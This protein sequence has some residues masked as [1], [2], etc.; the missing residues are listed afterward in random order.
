MNADI[1]YEISYG[2]AQVPLYCVYI[3][4]LVV[5]RIR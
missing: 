3:G 4:P 5:A 2:K 1:N